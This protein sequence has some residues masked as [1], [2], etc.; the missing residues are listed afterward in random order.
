MLLIQLMLTWAFFSCIL[1]FILSTTA[2][3]RYLIMSL[4]QN[5]QSGNVSNACSTL[6]GIIYM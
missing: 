3:V 2:L 4:R 1:F 6:N 5:P